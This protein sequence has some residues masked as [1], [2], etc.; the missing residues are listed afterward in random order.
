[1][2]MINHPTSTLSRRSGSSEVGAQRR[3][4]RI[5]AYSTLDITEDRQHQ[6]QHL[7]LKV[8]WSRDHS[9]HLAS[10]S[11]SWPSRRPILSP[12]QTLTPMGTIMKVAK[13][14][15]LMKPTPCAQE[16]KIVRMPQQLQHRSP[17]RRARSHPPKALWKPQQ[18][19]Q[20]GVRSLPGRH[21]LEVPQAPLQSRQIGQM[22]EGRCTARV[23]QVHPAAGA[24]RRQEQQ[25]FQQHHGRP[26]LTDQTA[27]RM[28][29]RRGKQHQSQLPYQ[30]ARRAMTPGR[31][32]QREVLPR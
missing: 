3:Q 1:M 4:A 6:L 7:R 25:S 14:A 5:S 26:R 22:M 21:A 24:M 8:P 18:P 2:Q 27:L 23:L 19:E 32:K 16:C 9:M 17:R 13:V 15:A 12:G 11:A 30:A 31:E 10:C 29:H 20:Q 28:R